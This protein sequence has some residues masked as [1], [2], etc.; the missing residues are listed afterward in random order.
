LKS[1]QK[2]NK[3][4]YLLAE[5]NK[6]EINLEFLKKVYFLRYLFDN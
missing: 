4:K 5:I 3:K 2:K 6:I 1:L